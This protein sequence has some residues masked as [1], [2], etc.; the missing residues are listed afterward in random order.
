V[1]YSLKDKF[2]FY[3]IPNAH[4]DWFHTL[5]LQSSPTCVESEVECPKELSKG[6]FSFTC[7]VNPYARLYLVYSH[8]RYK[9][10][11]KRYNYMKAGSWSFADFVID[12]VHCSDSLIPR[13]RP[14]VEYLPESL[15]CTL[16][17]ENLIEEY[18][19]VPFAD[20]VPLNRKVLSNQNASVRWIDIYTKSLCALVYNRYRQDFE[21]FGY[22]AEL[23]EKPAS[24][25][26]Y[27]RYRT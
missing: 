6:F 17:L 7:V 16:H 1:I 23:P 27:R 8:Y 3:D 25:S 18:A 12:Q 24:R 9:S 2:L 14:Q 10:S 11:D 13:V 20:E 15:D 5:L 4:P 19:A 21:R 26:F 22:G